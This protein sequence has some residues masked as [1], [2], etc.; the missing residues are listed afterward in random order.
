M[1]LNRAL[2]RFF[3]FCLTMAGPR[4]RRTRTLPIAAGSAHPGRSACRPRCS[5]A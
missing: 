3:C 4:H 2:S 1:S 5:G